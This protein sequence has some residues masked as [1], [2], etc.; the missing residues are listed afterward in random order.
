MLD[1]RE[2]RVREAERALQ[3]EKDRLVAEKNRIE[4]SRNQLNGG[5]VALPDGTALPVEDGRRKKRLRHKHAFSPNFNGKKNALSGSVQ[6]SL[7]QILKLYDHH[8]VLL[9]WELLKELREDLAVKE[10]DDKL[11]EA[12]EQ[13]KKLD[14]AAPEKLE[15]L[16]RLHSRFSELQRSLLADKSGWELVREAFGL[17]VRYQPQE[18][19]SVRVCMDAEM[20]APVFDILS[21]LREIDQWHTWVPSFGGI[22]LNNSKLIAKTSLLNMC[23]QCN[24]KLPAALQMED[25]QC[26][27]GVDGLVC[28]DE[29]GKTKQFAIL[30]D[31]HHAQENCPLDQRTEIAKLMEQANAE[32]LNA[33][34]LIT[35]Q[36]VPL[37]KGGEAKSETFMQVMAE[38]NP[39]TKAKMKVPKWLLNMFLRNFCFLILLEIQQSVKITRREP[40]VSLNTDPEFYNLIRK[41]MEESLHLKNEF[42]SLPKGQGQTDQLATPDDS[43]LDSAD[44]DM[45]MEQQ[46]DAAQDEARHEVNEYLVNS[47]TAERDKVEH[48]KQEIAKLLVENAAL[49]QQQE[50]MADQGTQTDPGKQCDQMQP[51]KVQHKTSSLRR[52]PRVSYG[53]KE[54]AVNSALYCSTMRTAR[55]NGTDEEHFFTPESPRSTA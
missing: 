41:R 12:L 17:E 4:A 27:F 16:E 13:C 22:S 54:Q 29:E 8:K 7:M 38:I 5:N 35:P 30:L 28:T 55:D 2:R 18:S 49:K 34:I 19:G 37:E 33:G 26:V 51:Q 24:I 25:R 45:E 14:S 50:G 53:S 23:L 21:L 6:E 48:L 43:D 44:A 40:F 3:V 47:P 9:A 36:G 20:Q 46:S 39:S 1:V 10:L 52:A 31:S 32:I 15:K 42:E 11:H